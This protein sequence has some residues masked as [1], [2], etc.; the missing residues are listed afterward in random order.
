MKDTATAQQIEHIIERIREAG[1]QAH[2]TRGEERTIVAAVGSGRRH[3]IEALQA[4]PGVDNVVPIAQPYKLVSRQVRPGG[5]V[6][7]V[8]GVRIGNGEPVV[9]IAGPCSVESRDQLLTTAR[10]VKSAGARLLRGGA[11]KPRTSPYDFQGLGEEALELLAEARRETGLPVVTEVMSTEDVDTI[12]E[13][14][15]ML[16]VGARNMQNYALLRRLATVNKPVLLKR[17]P[18][19]TVKEWLLAAEYLL[20]GGNPNVV[21]CERGIKTFETETRNTIDLAAVA[22]AKELSHLPVIA[23]PSHGT[24]RRSLIAPLSKAAIAVGADGLII[25]VHPNP[26]RA[27]S[28]GPQSLDCREFQAM[29]RELPLAKCAA[30]VA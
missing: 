12:C 3:E 28:D 4:A 30:A 14:A 10:A 15:D 25:E 13:R 22:L 2:I 5:T 11:Y 24:G 7:D 26:E 29:M 21:L 8:A 27:L 18:S 1:Y 17:G 20:T 19:A 9:V 23:D 6:V 16:Q